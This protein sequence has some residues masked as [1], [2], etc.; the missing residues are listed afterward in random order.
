MKWQNSDLEFMKSNYYKMSY[1][2]IAIY[3]N[4]NINTVK[5]KC[6]SLG[7]IRYNFSLWTKKEIDFLKEHYSD[8]SAV[9]LALKLNRS[10]DAIKKMAYRLKLKKS[11]LYLNKVLSHCNKYTKKM[12]LMNIDGRVGEA[13]SITEFCEKYHLNEVA[14]NAKYHLGG[15][16]YGSKRKMDSYFGWYDPKKLMKIAEN[17]IHE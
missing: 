16:L 15:I 13:N 7:L 11:K 8:Y 6:H 12:W 2:E 3:F 9:D 17:N 4:R 1:A 5:S 10:I 14:P